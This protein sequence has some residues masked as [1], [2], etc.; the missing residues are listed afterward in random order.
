MGFPRRVGSH[1]AAFDRPGAVWFAGRP[2]PSSALDELAKLIDWNS[3]AALL[4]PLYPVSKGEP[5][6]PPVAMVRALLLSIWFRRLMV[7]HNLDR[8]LFE[9]VTLQLKSKAEMVKTGTL[10]DAQHCLCQ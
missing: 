2:R 4:D 6:W 1:G 10:V 9:E 7:A 5:A 8:Q 3:V